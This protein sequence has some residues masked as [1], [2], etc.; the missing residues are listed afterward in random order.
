VRF[1]TFDGR[2]YGNNNAP[3]YRR[4]F[5]SI[6]NY[7]ENIPEYTDISRAIKVARDESRLYRFDVRQYLKDGYSDD[8][9]R[10][11]TH[12]L[13][14]YLAVNKKG[15]FR[16][17]LSGIYPFV[18]SPQ[19]AIPST[20]YTGSIARRNT[21]IAILG[22]VSLSLFLM[23]EGVKR[24]IYT[25]NTP[26]LKEYMRRLL[27]N[28][29]SEACDLII[30]QLVGLTKLRF[31][32]EATGCK[33]GNFCYKLLIDEILN[34]KIMGERGEESLNK[35]IFIE[36]FHLLEKMNNLGIANREIFFDTIIQTSVECNSLSDICSDISDRFCG[37]YQ[38]ALSRNP[39][40]IRV[41]LAQNNSIGRSVNQAND[42]EITP[43]INISLCDV[44]SRQPI[45]LIP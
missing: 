15:E 1:T 42:N 25:N 34:G 28:Y 37:I 44:N 22:T 6:P 2:L 17:N 9:I 12:M 16:E 41:T 29:S 39:N 14:G 10:K 31:Y 23:G 18:K 40:P 7:Y 20:L 24:R 3:Y 30:E 43:S 19:G 33:F 5:A 4:T 13:K 21:Q 38:E 26:R 8:D 27:I 36:A 32:N 11:F 35:Q 45:N